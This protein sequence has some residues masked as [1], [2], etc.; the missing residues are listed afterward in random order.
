[1]RSPALKNQSV[2][3]L[4]STRA[5]IDTALAER[6]RELEAMLGEISG[7]VT[8]RDGGR[9]TDSG[10]SHPLKG[11]KVAPK[12]RDNEGNSWSGRG[13]MPRWMRAAVDAGKKAEDFLINAAE[14][15]S[16]SVRSKMGGKKKPGRRGRPPKAGGR[17]RKA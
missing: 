13:A 10:R 8:S 15:V 16:S 7:R 1:M 4:L 17:S 12:Y 11:K 9:S 2:A 14:T 6:R 3:Q 5:D